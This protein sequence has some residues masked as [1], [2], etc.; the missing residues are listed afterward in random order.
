MQL[1]RLF[2]ALSPVFLFALAAAAA[3]PAALTL[4]NFETTTGAARGEGWST[5]GDGVIHLKGKG[6]NL[7]SKE[8]Y[9][10]FELEWEWKLTEG[11]NNGLK[12]WVTKIGGKEWLGVEYQ[13]IDDSKHADGLKGGSH[14]T[15]SFYDIKAPA[16]DKPLNPPG[17]WNKSKVVSNGG[18]LQHWLNGK[19][20]A[21]ADTASAEWKAGIAHSKFKSKEGFAPG[22]GR[23][24][25]T[26]HGDETWY[27]NIRIRPL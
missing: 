10:N 17:Q 5:D 22:K 26:D 24:M 11:G 2:L 15:A 27:R 14:V 8:E 21:E 25:L 1:R 4:A 12:Y 7:I 3:E 20:V 18:K 16:A 23:I 9:Q 13:M 6:G 19:L